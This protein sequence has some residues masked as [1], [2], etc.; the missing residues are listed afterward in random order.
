MQRERI[1][2]RPPGRMLAGC[3]LGVIG[4]GAIGGA[5]A[6]RAKALGMRVIATRRR[7][8]PGQRSPLA[9]ELHGPDGLERLLA[10]SD[11][12][13]LCAPDSP[14]TR[15]LIDAKALEQMKPGAV[16]VN[17]ARGALLDEPALIAALR[18]GRLRAAIL[19]VTRVEP[20]PPGDP[21]WDAPNL[22]LSPHCSVSPDAYV[23][24]MLDFLAENVGR[25]VRGE[26]LANRV[27]ADDVRALTGKGGALG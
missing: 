27:G 6:A 21:L 12:V 9:D 5:I 23:E 20:L 19:D 2:T 1:F 3:T 4:L 22:Y 26:P 18:S 7:W 13:V 11:A 8:Q 10:L 15:D 16:L 14:A 25:W 24:R 17:V